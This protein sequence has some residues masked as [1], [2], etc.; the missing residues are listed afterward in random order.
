MTSAL[1]TG[2]RCAC[3]PP[4]CVGIAPEATPSVSVVNAP[5]ERSVISRNPERNFAQS[6]VAGPEN[7]IK[8]ALEF[9]TDRCF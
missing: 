7:W 2:R 9:R 5:C 4:R 8:T 6:V 1:R 3:C